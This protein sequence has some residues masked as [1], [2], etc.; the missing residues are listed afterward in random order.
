MRRALRPRGSRRH[1]AGGWLRALAGLGG[2]TLTLGAAAGLAALVLAQPAMKAT[3]DGRIASALLS[4]TF[5]DREGRVIGRRGVDRDESVPLD[6]MPRHLVDA[7]LAIEDRR[8][9]HHPGIDPIGLARALL[10]NGR[11]GHVVQ[12][13]STITQQLAKILFLT[14]ERSLDRKVDEAFL[15]L[16]LEWRLSKPEILKL[17]LDHAYLGA[18][19]FG[20]A[21]ASRVYF[22]RSVEAIDLAQAATLAGLLKAPSVRAPHIDPAG[23]AARAGLVLDAMVA[24]GRLAPGDAASAR[25]HPAIA[26]GPGPRGEPAYALDWAFR[27]VQ[28][29]A[30]DGRFGRET[31]LTVRTALDSRMQAAADAALARVLSERGEADRIGQG[32]IVLLEPDGAIRAMTGGRD[33]R[34][35]AFNR[36]TDALRQPGSAFKPFVYAVALRDAGYGPDTIVWDEPV[37]LGTWC[38]GNYGGRHAGPLPLATALARSTNSVAV[39]LMSAIG[40]AAGAAAPT[41][42]A[43]E[44]RLRFGQLAYRMGIGTPLADT[45]ALTLGTSEVT[46]LDLSASYAVFANGGFRAHPHLVIEVLDANGRVLHR[47]G[48]PAPKRVLSPSV[49]AGMNRMLAAVPERG[50]GRRAALP[51][52]RS[53]GKTGTT[54]DHR[55]AWYVGFTGSFVAGVWLG[56]DDR[57]PMRAV[58]GGSHP[59]AIWREV[60]IAAEAGRAPR[61]LPFLDGEPRPDTDMP[62]RGNRAGRRLRGHGRAGLGLHG[63]RRRLRAA[64][65]R[66]I[67][68]GRARARPRGLRRGRPRPREAAPRTRRARSAPPSAWRATAPPRPPGSAASR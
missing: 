44:G 48:A 27:E 34:A 7:V 67:P 1:G 13:G 46:L 19:A 43:A 59:A 45:P 56:N 42:A 11:A 53:A 10:A 64:L 41:A 33:H 66:L 12:G 32:A 35:S 50:T 22:D 14:G 18:G 17:Y 49:V 61:P 30:R 62:C 55:D 15:A 9:A 20:M 57:S 52:I 25:A 5:L 60:M 36:A 28:R 47:H 65:T 68:C 51:G 24:T 58:T 4:V 2:E 63:P 39:Q 23:A 21:A 31:S 37:C 8:Y 6:R 54:D 26:T 38:P 3:G 16:W 29:L 40:N